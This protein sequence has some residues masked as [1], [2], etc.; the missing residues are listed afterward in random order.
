MRVLLMIAASAFVSGAGA[1][2]GMLA[3]L[4]CRIVGLAS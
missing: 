3:H 2:L 1:A 4:I